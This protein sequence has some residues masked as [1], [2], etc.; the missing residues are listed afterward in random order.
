MTEPSERAEPAKD[1]LEALLSVAVVVV[2]VGYRLAQVPG[3]DMDEAWSLL[4]ARG[5][6]EPADPLSGMTR[7]AG[8]LPVLLLRLSGAASS[9]TVLRFTSLVCN[10]L[11]MLLLARIV[12]TLHPSRSVRG[13]AL[14][15]LATLPAWLILARRGVEISMFGPMLAI[16]GIRLLLLRKGWATLAAGLSWGIA[17]YSH[18]LGVFVPLSLGAAWLLL[19]RRP[20]PLRWLPLLAG[21]ALGVA[22]RVVALLLFA[23]KVLD[24][25]AAR[26]R[27]GPALL[28]L[29]QL[30]LVLWQTL[31]GDAVYL[32]AVGYHR[33]MLLPYWLLAG[34]LLVPAAIG[35]RALPRA[36]WFTLL[37]SLILAVLGTVGTPRLAVRYMVLPCLGLSVFFVQA[38]A[39]AID[40]EL[41]WSRFVPY[42]AALLVA[43]NLF[44]LICNFYL[45]WQR[46]E[47]VIAR[48]PLGFRNPRESNNP[49][50]PK[51]ELVAQLGALAPEQIVTSPSLERPLRALL[52]ERIRVVGPADARR[53]LRSVLVAYAEPHT[54]RQR[55][56]AGAEGRLCYGPSRPLAKYYLLYPARSPGTAPVTPIGRHQ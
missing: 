12:Q 18:L 7:Y 54:A 44:Y 25:D 8:A 2:L 56:V 31:N 50:L 10:A 36:A 48:F 21:F 40:A 49:Y 16:L 43:G 41:R 28:D 53:K 20:P 13:W 27:L 51:D 26:Y 32:R 9:H 6:A 39:A 35:R 30:P 42:V 29:T 17:A 3:L 1:T 23:D 15:L 37:A 46:D 14:P 11:A 55:C 34:L 45:P 47:L 22:P 24:G 33:V 4:A 38:G 52:P 19:Y 5:Q